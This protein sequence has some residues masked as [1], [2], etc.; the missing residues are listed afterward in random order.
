MKNFIISLA[1]LGGAAL[2]P[3]HAATMASQPWT[4]NRIAEA[5]ARVNARI[6][7][8]T[9]AIGATASD[10]WQ[11]ATDALGGLSGVAQSATNYTDAVAAEFENGTRQV[12]SAQ[13]AGS[14]SD[15]MFAYK[16]SG[17]NWNDQYNANDLMRAS[18]NAARAVVAPV[19]VAA[20][21]YTDAAT[22]ALAQTIPQGVG[23]PEWREV[24]CDT[25]L[26]PY[27]KFVTNGMARVVIDIIVGADTN[28]WPNGAS[29]F[30]EGVV[31]SAYTPL[32]PLRLVGYGTWPTNN[33]Q[34]VWWRS[35]TN[36]F[37]NILL[38]EWP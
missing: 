22:N 31:F 10:A 6:T 30:V 8:A 12:E 23:M 9:N 21:N 7:S 29:M 20:T 15:A 11:M 3:L 27:V 33:F 26:N 17:D 1:L 28:G 35:G 19:A 2:L 32:P 24:D 4:T 37:V 34:S 13:Y 18:T 16:V 14:S 25:M 5:E 36:I 38:E